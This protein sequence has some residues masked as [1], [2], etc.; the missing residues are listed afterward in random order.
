[1]T[2]CGIFSAFYYIE[3]SGFSYKNIHDFL[4]NMPDKINVCI[5]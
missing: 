4:D 5:F 2:Q 1:M 3:N